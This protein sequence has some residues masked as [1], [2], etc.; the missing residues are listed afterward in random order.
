MGDARW[1]VVGLTD[2]LVEGVVNS[3]VIKHKE[4]QF[5]DVGGPASWRMNLARGR[6]IW[7]KHFIRSAAPPE[8]P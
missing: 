3:E 6:L 8:N 7:S 2:M 1:V 5:N 4:V